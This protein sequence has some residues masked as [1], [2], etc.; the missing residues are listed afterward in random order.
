M[1]NNKE[2]ILN[3][4][5]D[6][7]SDEQIKSKYE[8][9][10]KLVDHKKN[11]LVLGTLPNL[12]SKSLSEKNC[13]VTFIEKN[14]FENK[15]VDD[16]NDSLKNKQFDVI[17]L[18]DFLEY[19]KESEKVLNKIQKLLNVN[20]CIVCS[21]PN[22]SHINYRIQLLN[23]DLTYQMKNGN[24]EILLQMFTLD[25]ILVLLESTR[26]SINK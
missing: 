16:A 21:L 19:L 8:A 25:I 1:K 12:L 15:I 6:S 7:M 14:N 23:G 9:I 4:S 10:M 2:E 22:I 24:K 26:F 5:Q 3:T 13:N 18:F 20:G 11:V 17:I